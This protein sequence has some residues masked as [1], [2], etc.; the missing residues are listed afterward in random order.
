MI[1]AAWKQRMR[2]ARSLAAVVLL[3][4]AAW[5]LG[6]AGCTQ[7]QQPA[8][9]G[10]PAGR[11][12]SGAQ[13][14][15]ESPKATDELRVLYSGRGNVTFFWYRNGKVLTGQNGP[16]LPAGNFTKG[17]AVT[18][19]VKSD[20]GEERASVV[21]RNSPPVVVSFVTD[22]EAVHAGVDMTVVPKIIHADGDQA[23]YRVQ[24]AVNGQTQ[25][26]VQA[27]LPAAAFRKGDRVSVTIIP[28]DDEGDGETFTSKPLVIPNAP[29]LFVST[30]VTAFSADGY[31]YQAR[32]ADPDG[33]KVLYS[34]TSAPNGMTIDRDTGLISW[35]LEKA[36]AGE[37]TIE[38]EARDT[39]GMRA[40]QRYSLI[41]T[42]PEEAKSEK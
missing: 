27:T 8:A 22:P 15:P 12:L 33:D 31:R 17:D 10:G 29:P 4:S 32:A 23:G 9:G 11:T 35:P 2:N 5:G 1:N 36:R 6:P 3:A 30:P 21:I 38:I 16:T 39:D 20:G 34:L 13:L 25:P 19:V 42:M 18:A 14:I 26:G 40:T 37:H 41:V 24:F 28:Y 7:A